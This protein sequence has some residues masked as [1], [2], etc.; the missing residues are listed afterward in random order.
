MSLR[1]KLVLS[2]GIP[3][4]IVY[5]VLIWVQFA[6]LRDTALANAQ[7]SARMSAESW[8][9]TFNG[10]LHGV[11]Q[12]VDAIAYA[13]AMQASLEE[14]DL[15]R[16]NEQLMD[17]NDLVAGSSVA[18]EPRQWRTDVDR[19]SPYA[20]Q[21]DGDKQRRD[22]AQ[23]YDYTT[24][25]WYTEGADGSPGWTEPYDGPVFGS[26]LVTYSTP[27]VRSGQVIGVVAADIAL[28][29][30]QRQLKE[31]GPQGMTTM[32]ASPE[33]T[34]IVHPDPE[35]I[36]SHSLQSEADRT[37]VAELAAWS[38]DI[39]A[40]APGFQQ[41][42]GYPTNRDHWLLYTP[43]AATDWSMAAA[44]AEEDILAPV[45]RQLVLN[46][47]LM[48]VGLLALLAIITVT[49]FRIVRPVR[50]LAGAV[51]RLG[52]GDLDV[53]VDPPPGR[54][55]IGELARGFNDMTERLQENIRVLALE[56]A[57]R[58]RV[59]GEMQMARNIQEM[60]LPKAFPA[61][62]DRDE[63]ELWALNEPARVV[64]GDFF[65]VIDNG[66]RI[67]VVMADVSGKGAGA[68][69]FM[70]MVHTIIRIFD[71]DNLP[72]PTLVQR[73]NQCLYPES[74]GAMFVTL[75]I[76]RYEPSTGS[77][78]LVNGGHPP[79][80][81]MTA[82]GAVELVGQSTGPLV[83]ALEGVEWSAVQTTLEP[84]E[85]LL[86]YTDG[87]TEAKDA[88]DVMLGVP[89]LLDLLRSDDLQKGSGDAIC[90]GLVEAIHNREPGEASDDITVLVLGRL[91]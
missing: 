49:G 31:S 47:I 88:A 25:E 68:A 86:L 48:G 32:L 19:Y 40:G 55:E 37:G 91:R 60:L 82:T 9:N 74:K 23:E 18:F 1:W 45:H 39:Q 89:G 85:Q 15:Y 50:T 90:K 13:V 28:L 17:Q 83:G 11:A 75:V 81:R 66:D 34:F 10:Q 53:R 33:G 42:D 12:A 71:S 59:E 62:I 70:S 35:R 69:M 38:R 27:V 6:A 4:L 14:D 52:G 87:I 78:E 30:L 51:R 80:I 84:K 20:W 58:E 57:A 43:V 72:L 64:A 41:L 56:T 29:P 3:V 16:F 24:R 77:M 2:I 7:A 21:V 54:D 36:F 63:V 46:L 44:F 5:G 79:P 73:L 65:D 22:L 67:T 61:L 26:L 76:L 8:A